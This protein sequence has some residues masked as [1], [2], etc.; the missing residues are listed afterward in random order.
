MAV[1]GVSKLHAVIGGFHLGPAPFDYIEYTIDELAGLA[2]DVV[3]PMHCSG[4]NFINAMRRRLPDKLVTS[5][6]GSKFIFEG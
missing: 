5:N 4:V 2:P 1:S 3:L 6:V